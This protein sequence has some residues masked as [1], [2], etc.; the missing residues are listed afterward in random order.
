VKGGTF[1]SCFEL[2][3]LNSSPSLLNHDSSLDRK[4]NE[5]LPFGFQ[6]FDTFMKQTFPVFKSLLWSHLPHCLTILVLTMVATTSVWSDRVLIEYKTGTQ[7]DARFERSFSLYVP[8]N[9]SA[10]PFVNEGPF[11][12]TLKSHLII[13]ARQDVIFE[14][15]GQGDAELHLNEKEILNSLDVSSEPI[16]LSEG[17]HDVLIQFKSTQG[18]D[19]SLRLFWKTA[20][21]DF[22]PIPSSAL[23]KPEVKL[24]QPL[25]TARNLLAQQKCIACH[26]TT[27]Q[28]AMPELLEKGPSLDGI[29]SRLNPAWIAAWIANPSAMRSDAHMPTMFRDESAGE[30]AAHIA[31]FLASSR[32][33]VKRLGGGD[34]KSGGQ[35]FQELG[36]YAC[37]SIHDETSDRI[38]L[39]SVDKKFQ[40]GVL[41]AFLQTPSQHYPD[42]RMPAFALSDSEAEN[43]AAFL[44]SLNKNKDF[45]KELTFGN[46]DIGKNLV[47]SS[48]CLNCHEMEGMENTLT[49][50]DL[51]T[52]LN[53][54]DGC[55]NPAS[56]QTSAPLF[57]TD[58][59]A[60]NQVKDP[61][62]KLIPSLAKKNL[63]EY[64]H[65]QFTTLNCVACHQRDSIPS[66]REQLS[67]EVAHLAQASTA[68]SEEE[69]AGHAP[70]KIPALDHLGIKLKSEWL[71][72]I[73]EGNAP[74]KTRPWLKA[75]MPAWPSRAENLANGFAH[76]A[77][78]SS[79]SE[80]TN[81]GRLR[82][83]RSVKN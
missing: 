31:T 75:R 76:A 61:A 54:E 68:S 5:P 73:L 8:T 6:N 35:L 1:P 45:K 43:L 66:L 12:A 79:T 21:F 59:T 16:T 22:E 46:P 57:N 65:R 63:T 40:N 24:D 50:P 82:A 56:K 13:N 71:T 83:L 69:S 20:E 53:S 48:G 55:R 74:E 4:V 70:Q 67:E 58:L 25:R 34:P 14:L 42:S 18:E 39:L 51:L 29:G 2:L 77:G 47:V 52:V 17:R 32:G 41:A 30:K 62:E 81:P 26:Q 23:V 27:A 15:R 64:S 28:L 38:S 9:E 19:A 3:F 36:C 37:H 7:S 44:R 80:D 10:T 78:I 33:R 11:E 72:S 49:A 60:L